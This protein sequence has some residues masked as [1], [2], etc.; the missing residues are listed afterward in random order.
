MEQT[1]LKRILS[2][3]NVPIA[4]VLSGYGLEHFFHYCPYFS[5]QISLQHMC[6]KCQPSHGQ[7]YVPIRPPNNKEI[8]TDKTS[9]YF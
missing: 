6:L 1:H 9:I 5:S 3:K 8:I 7:I 2:M 4:F